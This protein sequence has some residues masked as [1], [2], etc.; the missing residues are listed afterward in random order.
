M[1]QT[2]F[3]TA[4]LLFAASLFLTSCD[5]KDKGNTTNPTAIEGVWTLTKVK[6]SDAGDIFESEFDYT[7]P[8]RNLECTYLGIPEIITL[9]HVGNDK[10]AFYLFVFNPEELTWFKYDADGEYLIIKDN[11]LTLDGE[12]DGFI[13]FKNLTENSATLGIGD[14]DF[15]I[16]LNFKKLSGNPDDVDNFIEYEEFTFDDPEYVKNIFSSLK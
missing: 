11:M 9:K 15:M 8:M 6:M 12:E 7:N 13:P 2:T 16:T 4:F 14:A 1:K 5:P 3:I 10:Y